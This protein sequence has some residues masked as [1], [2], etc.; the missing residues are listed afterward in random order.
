LLWAA[1]PICVAV[2][3]SVL[4]TQVNSYS[5]VQHE[6]ALLLTDVGRL[7]AHEHFIQE[8]ILAVGPG[9]PVDDLLPVRAQLADDFTQLRNLG[10]DPQGTASLAAA[11]KAYETALDTEV[12]QNVS[13]QTAATR[14]TN[15]DATDS[16]FS[17]LNTIIDAGISAST[18]QGQTVDGYSGIAIVVIIL[19]S[20]LVMSALL[21]L[22]ERRRRVLAASIIE[23]SVVASSEARFRSLVENSSDFLLVLAGDRKVVLQSAAGTR[24]FGL[25]P[26]ALVGVDVLDWVEP[27]DRDHVELQLVAGEG[28][29]LGAH[30]EC[31]VRHTDGTLRHVEIAVSRLP[32]DSNVQGIVLNCRDITD[33]KTLEDE[34]AHQALHDG[35]TGLP[36]R[37]LF[38][39]RVAHAIA[40]AQR[41]KQPT[42]AMVIDLNGFKAV[43]D[44]LGHAAGDALLVAFAGALEKGIRPGDTAARLGGDEFA[45][46]LENTDGA[47]AERIGAR[48]TSAP[49][50]ASWAD[51][52]VSV[53]A[54]IGVADGK[55]TT[56]V[57]ELMRHADAAM[58]SAKSRGRAGVE[59]FD[60]VTHKLFLNRLELRMDLE[61]A[62]ERGELTVHYQPLINL[63]SGAVV[64]VEA[65]LRWRHP[66]RGMIAPLDFI[67]LAEETGLIVPIGLWTIE[68]ACQDLRAWQAGGAAPGMGVSVNVSLRQLHDPAFVGQVKEILTRLEVTPSLLT[69]EVTESMLAGE[70]EHLV[71]ILDGL[72]VLGV[73]IALDDFGTGYS[74]LS[75]LRDLPLDTVKIDRSFVSGVATEESDREYSL[76]IVRLLGTVDAKTVA[77]GIE[78]VSQLDYM[79]AMGCD[80]GQ[81]FLF[82]RPVDASG[83]GHFLK[84][85]RPQLATGS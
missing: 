55:A 11:V 5:D 51:H 66:D 8:D 1:I 65:L 13:D 57:E 46:L 56:T 23:S 73:R 58:Y 21:A 24:L 85:Q 82:S 10:H 61:M 22:G 29:L 50:T 72:R 80:L 27:D 38:A 59:V 37:A 69:L 35:L 54:S 81:G 17:T 52:E 68:T 14:R 75:Y 44:T 63:E 70:P 4:V 32:D 15:S 9:A 83:I 39:N 48:L 49:V 2:V 84:Q 19:G 30:V 60:P 18:A 25:P 40:A 3:A 20:A 74:S 67:P 26:D 79:K 34:L 6:A 36:N 33:R 43:N 62:V 76:A 64:D 53:S 12:R 31:R 41:S 71:K 77:E 7:T 42:S 16:T 47:A 28:G 45:V 78:D